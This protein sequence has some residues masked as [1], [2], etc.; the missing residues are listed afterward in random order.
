MYPKGGD[1]DSLPR[2]LDV[3]PDL[4]FV[5]RSE[6]PHN[7]NDKKDKQQINVEN[8]NILDIIF[9]CAFVRAEEKEKE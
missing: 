9:M 3:D 1:E 7:N 5:L 8:K 2:V 6:N 4:I